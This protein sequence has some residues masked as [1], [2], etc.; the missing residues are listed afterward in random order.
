MDRTGVRQGRKGGKRRRVENRRKGLRAGRQR[1]QA[2]CMARAPLHMRQI[3]EI[4]RLRHQGQL[5]VRDIA[6]SCGLP[7]STVGDYLKRAEAVNLGWPLPEGLS[8]KQ[9]QDQLLGC[10]QP[11]APTSDSSK[12]LPD[13]AQL[14]QEG[15]SS[16]APSSDKRPA[17]GCARQGCRTH[18]H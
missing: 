12:P 8:Q 6:R 16:G 18:Q 2:T 17:I 11:T 14:R 3:N 13:W 4:L 5:S 15:V 7:A 9:L 1:R 10:P